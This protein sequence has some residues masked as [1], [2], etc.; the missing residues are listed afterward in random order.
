MIRHLPS[1]P[2]KDGATW[3]THTRLGV[4]H[5]NHVTQRFWGLS[6]VPSPSTKPTTQQIHTPN[7]NAQTQPMWSTT[8]PLYK[9]PL[10]RQAS[11]LR[12]TWDRDRSTET[13]GSF[14]FFFLVGGG[15]LLRLVGIVAL[16][17]HMG[18]LSGMLFGAVFGALAAAF[19]RPLFGGLGLGPCP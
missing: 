2:S 17:G 9:P 10:L 7:K 14:I 5:A 13:Q 15:R 16:R 12:T 18:V 1:A 4:R 6:R 3:E 11:P 8:H 19:P